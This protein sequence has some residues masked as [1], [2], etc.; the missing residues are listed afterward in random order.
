MT[1]KLLAATVLLG[2]SGTVLG[3]NRD[4]LGSSPAACRVQ[5]VWERVATIQSGKRTDYAGAWERKIV[6]KKHFMWL[7]GA[8]RRDTLPLRTAL[9]SARFYGINGGSGTYEV[10]GHRYTE[11]IDRFVDPRVEG[12]S[13]TTSCRTE[14]KLWYHTLLM[15]DLGGAGTG[16]SATDSTTE[17]WRRSE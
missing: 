1:K 10:A 13:L 8:T 16:R 7:G 14:G 12:K 3:S 17:V 11:H 9:D 2:I 5:G 4:V 15:S 6:T